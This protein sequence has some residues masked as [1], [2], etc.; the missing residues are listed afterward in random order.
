MASKNI[1]IRKEVYDR[2]KSERQPGES[3][4]DTINR[5]LKEETPPLTQFAGV[6]SN[7]T[8]KKMNKAMEELSKIEESEIKRMLEE[9][10]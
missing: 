4:T 7:E 10:E 9:R 1:S 8:G 5:L 2:L 3:F 6:I